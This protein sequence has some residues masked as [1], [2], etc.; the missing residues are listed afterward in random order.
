MIATIAL[1]VALTAAPA[2]FDTV[3]G[4]VTEDDYNVTF[5]NPYAEFDA[6]EYLFGVPSEQ[7]VEIDTSV[8]ASHRPREF[9][10]EEL[11]TV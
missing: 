3:D 1:A 11:P 6:M 4:F 7:Y 9:G 10:G 8:P 5:A 2:G